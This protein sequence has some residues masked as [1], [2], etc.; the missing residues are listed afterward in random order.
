MCGFVCVWT[1][2]GGDQTRKSDKYGMS[3]RCLGGSRLPFYQFVFVCMQVHKCP[4]ITR[5]TVQFSEKQQIKNT[6]I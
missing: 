3:L 5:F 4:G 1:G 6:T 2:W